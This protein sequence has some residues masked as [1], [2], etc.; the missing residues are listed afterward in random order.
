MMNGN[1]ALAPTP[2]RDMLAAGI[3]I[4][5]DRK[6]NV[7]AKRLKRGECPT[8]GT[9]THKVSFLGKNKPLTVEGQV[10]KGRCLICHPLEGYIRRPPPNPQQTGGGQHPDAPLVI[11]RTLE[12]GN[13]Y[14]DE[15]FSV[16]SGITMDMRLIQGARNWQPSD[17][18]DYESDDEPPP[19]PRGGRPEPSL[20]GDDPYEDSMP[21]PGGGVIR[22]PRTMPSYTQS[23]R[24]LGLRNASNREFGGGPPTSRKL[25]PLA[26][27]GSQ[28]QHHGRFPPKTQQQRG[29]SQVPMHNARTRQPPPHGLDGNANQSDY[30]N[31]PP[32]H[33]HGYR[34]HVQPNDSYDYPDEQQQ[35]REEDQNYTSNVA[36]YPS[37]NGPNGPLLDADGYPIA[38]SSH[39]WNR[40]EDMLPPGGM[41]SLFRRKPSVN[42]QH[43]QSITSNIGEIEFNPTQKMAPATGQESDPHIPRG[44]IQFNSGEVGE[45]DDDLEGPSK[46]E[47][48]ESGPMYQSDDFPTYVDD[49]VMPPPS[50]GLSTQ[51][52]MPLFKNAPNGTREDGRFNMEDTMAAPPMLQSSKTTG[53]EMFSR[54]NNRLPPDRPGM[55]ARMDSQHTTGT[56]DTSVGPPLINRE[57]RGRPDDDNI[58]DPMFNTAAPVG[59][60][61]MG[62]VGADPQM[63]PYRTDNSQT[64]YNSEMMDM[65]GVNKDIYQINEPSRGEESMPSEDPYHDGGRDY[66]DGQPDYNDEHRR[67]DNGQPGYDDSH[68]YLEDPNDVHHPGNY[69]IDTGR[70]FEQHHVHDKEP[71]LRYDDDKGMPPGQVLVGRGEYAASAIS[72]G[73]MFDDDIDEKAGL[74]GGYNRGD[75]NGN[76]QND[77]G[78]GMNISTSLHH[79]DRVRD[80]RDNSNVGIRDNGQKARRN[81]A[82]DVAG[83]KDSSSH[84]EH[85]MRSLASHEYDIGDSSGLNRFGDHKASIDNPNSDMMAA[86]AAPAHAEAAAASP[87]MAR[88]PPPAQVTSM[89]RKLS[90]TEDDDLTETRSKSP[91]PK[92]DR[93][94]DK[95][96]QSIHDIPAILHCLGL[97]EANSNLREKALISLSEILWKSGEKARSFIVEHKGVETLVSTMWADISDSKVQAA[98]LAFL[99]SL[100]AS[101]NGKAA[102][103]MLSNEESICD[104]LLFSMQ[105]HVSDPG[106][107][108]HGCA[109]LACLASASSNNTKVSDGSLSGGLLMVLNAMGHHNRSREIQK[110]GLHALYNQ[111]LLSINAESN[112]RSLMECILDNGNTGMD[113]VLSAMTSLQ[114]DV[115]AME[116][117]CRL[118]WCLASSQD[119]VKSL[120]NTSVIE[121]ISEL[122]QRYTLN[123]EATALVEAAF[124]VIANLSYLENKRSELERVGVV[125]CLIDGIRHHLNDCGV[126]IEACSAIANLGVSPPVREAM[127]RSGAVDSVVHAIETFCDDEDLMSE[128]SRALVCLTIDSKHT[129]ESIAVP[130]VIN[131]VVESS[132]KH[133]EGSQLHGMTCALFASLAVGG[134]S[135]TADSIV[136]NGG[137]DVIV[138]ALAAT[139]DEKVRD[140]ACLAYRNLACELEDSDRILQKGATK[141]IVEAMGKFNNCLSIQM[142]ACCAIW[143]LAYKTER[144]PGTIVGSDGIK[145]IV[146]AMQSHLESGE[147]LELACGALGSLVDGNSIERKKDV[148][149]NGAIDAVACAVVM[150]PGRVSTLEKAFGVLSN[151]SLERPLA[152]AIVNAQGVNILAEAMRNNGSSVSVLEAGCTALRNL[153]FQF[154]DFAPEASSVV[155]VVINAMKE[156]PDEVGF[157]Q[158]A[159]NLLWVLAAEAENCQSK[160]LALDGVAVVMKCMEIPEVQESALGAFRQLASGSN[161]SLP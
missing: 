32:S 123:S 99:F 65:N 132:K 159:C 46:I 42:P 63:P 118:C 110:A 143:N 12:V 144:E 22:P 151:V 14:D 13:N 53:P 83:L 115:V 29:Q 7:G 68:G 50:T 18:V 74:A 105:T 5:P 89:F 94:K 16:V 156:N 106:I 1:A 9:Q 137:V 78:Y 67:D 146:R 158:E 87:A 111:C 39:G 59:M 61:S 33:Q 43:H 112:K 135:A 134:A 40:E 109:I 131:S 147:L 56:G 93:P 47:S 149:G 41:D 96:D 114:D 81:P 85:G 2:E 76:V 138:Q 145:N 88:T 58:Q 6:N 155:S 69:G 101:P 82:Y 48:M 62:V 153:I 154:P 52:T 15:D 140:A 124:G 55:A 30:R 122:C 126:N 54:F 45:G 133:R 129:K 23:I 90:L 71:S 142:N 160:I 152:E 107:Q 98:A 4:I 34:E 97:D 77:I 116:W 92:K 26:P 150:H 75:R 11:P 148:V 80:P 125:P 66:D 100:S 3:D 37:G 20:G 51:K 10:Y 121:I 136:G 119:L 19:G 113:A 86:S 17:G 70:Q 130:D 73:P 79:S 95:K 35:M 141:G 8:C 27:S 36:G 72:D 64:I 117:A 44:E 57:R 84:D 91:K 108:L 127:V 139:S 49:D 102:G 25:P 120:A 157:Q 24:N 28:G 128:A 60:M 103:D 21:D 31:L 104:T 38:S 161:M